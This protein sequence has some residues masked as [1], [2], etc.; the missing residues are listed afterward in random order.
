VA[1]FYD[2]RRH[3]LEEATIV[4][5]E[6]HRA[7]EARERLF[8]DLRRGDVEVVRRLVEEE[9]VARLEQQLGERE[10]APLA[11]REALHARGT[12]RR[13][14]SGN[15]R[16]VLRAR[17]DVHVA[18]HAADLLD[19]LARGIERAEVLIEV[20]LAQ[21]G[22]APHLALVLGL[23]AP[24]SSFSSVD[25]PAPLGPTMPMRSPRRTSSSTPLEERAPAPLG[26][27]SARVEHDVAR[28][29]RLG[30]NESAPSRRRPRCPPG[31]PPCRACR[32]SCGGSAPASSS[33]RRC[34]CG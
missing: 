28:A 22:A 24:A 18:A 4:R 34:S 11:A 26:A 5:H 7:L 8:E 30:A 12:D 16:E 20:A 15:A 9:Q 23:A 32:A 33:A 19:A 25:F 6:Q 17:V 1:D 3:G 10:P 2:A 29:R 21:V 31:D 14:R 13:R 27:E